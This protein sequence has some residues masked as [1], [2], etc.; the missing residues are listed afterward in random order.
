MHLIVGA[1]GTVGSRVAQR[2]LAR[3]DVVRAVSRDIKKLEELRRLGGVPMTGDLRSQRWMGA[4]LEG[5]RSLILASHGLVPPT[6]DNHPG[7]VDDVGN[8]RIIDAARQAGVE[9]VVFVSAAPVAG[10]STLFTTAKY[11]VEE[12]L[13]R[14]GLSCAAVRPTV[15]IETHALL[16]LAEPLRAT[17]SVRFF[18]PG[19]AVLNWISADDV[20]EYVVRMVD[21]A[22]CH[23]VDAIG[24]PDNLSRRDVLE[25]VEQALGRRAR[26]AHVPVAAMRV[27]RAVVGSFH[28]G[29]RYLLDMALAET[30][31]HDGASGPLFDWTGPT[32]VSQ[33]VQRWV[34]ERVT[35]DDR[36]EMAV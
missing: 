26:R 16:L 11:R 19:T 4:A 10:Q 9:H 34:G 13:K 24:G 23:R 31:A 18:G 28:P 15:F 21:A 29:M 30:K 36:G 22:P 25:I 12:Y 14:S 20:A 32:A 8:R 2:L 35:Q 33:V 3:G 17:G 27:M 6:R 5:V 7:L 1:S